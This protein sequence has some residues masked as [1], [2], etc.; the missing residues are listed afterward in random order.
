MSDD[1]APDGQVR[2]IEAL[3]RLGA[4]HAQLRRTIEAQRLVQAEIAALRA[5]VGQARDPENLSPW[6]PNNPPLPGTEP[7]R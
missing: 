5:R 3:D 6:G 7:S 4:L 1:R 2:L